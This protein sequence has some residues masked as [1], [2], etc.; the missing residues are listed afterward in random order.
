MARHDTQVHSVGR[1]GWFAVGALAA[2]VAF[3]LLFIASDYFKAVSSQPDAE[4]NMP[5]LVIEGQ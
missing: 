4:A 2:S 5:A 3:V 1:A